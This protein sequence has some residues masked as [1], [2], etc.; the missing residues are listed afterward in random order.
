MNRYVVIDSIARSG[1][2]I[3]TNLIDNQNSCLAIPGAFPESIGAKLNITWPHGFAKH[4]I[5]D[6]SWVPFNSKKF[7]ERRHNIIPSNKWNNF[8]FETFE[9]ID[10]LYDEL[11]ESKKSK[12]LF[13]RWNQSLFWINKWRSRLAHHWVTIIRNPMSVAQ[14]AANKWTEDWSYNQ[15]LATIEAYFNNLVK[16]QHKTNI[17]YYEDLIHD[18]KKVITGL[19]KN[20]GVDIQYYKPMHLNKEPLNRYMHV[21]NKIREKFKKRLAKNPLLSR[22]F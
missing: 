7:I 19:F 10:K 11:L 12:Y 15:S 20:I 6:D 9:D 5:L 3:L 14:S 4:K 2:T 8:E 17:V 22:F 13:L 1:T 21:P 16:V 18:Q